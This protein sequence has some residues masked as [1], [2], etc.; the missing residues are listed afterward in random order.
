MKTKINLMLFGGSKRVS[1]IER[2]IYAAQQL[3][4]EANIFS[5]ELSDQVPISKYATIIVGKRWHDADCEAHI[6]S[7][8]DKMN[9]N[10]VLPCV[11]PAI[12]ILSKLKKNTKLETFKFIN[13]LSISEVF[14]NKVLANE[15]FLKHNFCVPSQKIEFPLIAKPIYGSASKGI[16]ILESKSEYDRFREKNSLADYLIQRF[17]DGIEYTVDAYVSPTNDFLEVV[18]R[19][20]ISTAGGEAVISE[21]INFPELT[22]ISRKVISDANLIGPNTIQ[23][24][25]DKF[26][27]EIYIMEVNTRLGGGVILSIEAGFNIPFLILSDYLN[28]NY[29]SK[30]EHIKQIWMFRYFKEV[31]FETHNRS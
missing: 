18:P 4:V 13:D 19:K 1:L 15:W 31:F 6:L 29:N 3:E 16:K 26:T 2:F 8:I 22:E 10:I 28:K 17:I 27:N 14:Y 25:V 11:D 7:I 23:Y 12:L 24:I 9:I 21:I 20:R 5:Y 30:L